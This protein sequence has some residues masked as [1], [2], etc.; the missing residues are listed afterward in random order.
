VRS[1]AGDN[2]ADRI[3][4]IWPDGTIEKEWLQV[5]VKDT[6]ATGLK[7]PDVFYFG[8]APG[9]AGNAFMN[10]L[11]NASDEIEARNDPHTVLNPAPIT[12]RHDYNRDGF[13]NAS[14]QIIARN[15]ATTVATAL[16]LIS[17]PG[18]AIE[19]SIS[20]S[21]FAD[22]QPIPKK[23]TADGENVSPP[24]AWEGVPNGTKQ[25]ALIMDDPDAPTQN[26]FVHWVIYKLDPTL[27][28]LPEGIAKVAEPATPVGAVQGRN[29][30]GGF[31]Y[32][33][34]SPPAGPVHHYHFTL[35]ALDTELTQSTALS[36]RSLEEAMAGHILAHTMLVG[37]Y[38]RTK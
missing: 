37:M 20:S 34:P 2:G 14:D 32:T 12:N 11:V 35:Y 16:R 38:E 26:P 1:G 25:L 4:L 29:G 22:G 17:T 36:K 13:V 31:G 5:A 28:G 6:A 24:L 15:N 9:E 7:K 23:Y 21:A 18:S 3:T 30:A 27:T 10:A 19:F 33:G 8:N